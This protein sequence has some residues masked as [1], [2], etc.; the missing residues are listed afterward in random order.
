M[1]YPFIIP[2][3]VDQYY[4]AVEDRWG[5]RETTGVYLLF[6]WTKFLLRVL[7]QIQGDSYDSCNDDED[8]ISCEWMKELFLESSDPSLIKKVRQ[9]YEALY[10]ID[11]QW[12]TYRKVALGEM[13]NISDVFITLIQ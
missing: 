1:R 13:F 7:S 9:K 5:G 2:A 6:H 12:V 11:K 4:G 8:I 3:L 10:G